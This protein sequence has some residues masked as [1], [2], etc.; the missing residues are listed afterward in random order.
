MQSMMLKASAAALIVLATG[1]ADM[2]A[3]AGNQTSYAT[4]SYRM[5]PKAQVTP[6]MTAQSNG[7]ATAP[8]SRTRSSAP[9]DTT[10]VVA[11]Q[12]ALTRHGYNVGNA[13]GT[14]DAPTHDALVQFQRANGL[15][16]TG[17]LDSNTM[18]ALGLP[19]Q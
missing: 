19:T 1:C 11:A 17:D 4:G 18:S 7:N 8:D 5:P 3:P 2:R 6:P 15:R 10:K 14:L 12:H 16:A 9:V 13:T